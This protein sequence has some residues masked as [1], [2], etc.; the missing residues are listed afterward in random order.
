MARHLNQ[1]AGKAVLYGGVP[2][3]DALKFVTLKSCKD[4]CT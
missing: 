3:E 1:E 4:A 2:E